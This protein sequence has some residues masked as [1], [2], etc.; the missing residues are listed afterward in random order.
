MRLGV[1]IL[2]EAATGQPVMGGHRFLRVFS[3]GHLT[4]R[5]VLAEMR[6]HLEHAVL[7]D[8]LT[9]RVELT[10]AELLTNI[11]E[12]AFEGARGSKV[13]VDVDTSNERVKV[14]ICDHGKPMPGGVLP[15]GLLPDIDVAR[16]DIPEHG[17]GLHI[18]RALTDRLDYHRMGGQNW[19]T[20]EFDIG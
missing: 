16:A 15:A 18:I 20:V 5:D 2:D 10:L 8:N 6:G 3:I 4:I 9:S 1:A 11:L 17:F 7:D 19:T 13:I 12:H 14:V